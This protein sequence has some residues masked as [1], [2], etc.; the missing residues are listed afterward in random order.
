MSCF[1]ACAVLPQS[2]DEQL[3]TFEQEQAKVKNELYE[4]IETLK[5]ELQTQE[6]L[7]QENLTSMDGQCAELAAKVEGLMK[8]LASREEQWETFEKEAKAKETD[9]VAQIEAIKKEFEAKEK[10]QKECIEAK[11][12]EC[13]E[14]SSKMELLSSEMKK[15][16]QQ[17]TSFRKQREK[18]SEA[19]AEMKRALKEKRDEIVGLST[20]MELFVGELKSREERVVSIEQ[21]IE[22]K[23]EITAE[24]MVLWKRDLEEQRA[25]QEEW[26]TK[27]TKLERLMEEREAECK[28]LTT[29]LEKLTEELKTAVE[30]VSALESAIADKE[31]GASSKAESLRK[32]LEEEQTQRSNWNDKLIEINR[33]LSEGEEACASLTARLE[34]FNLELQARETIVTNLEE[35]VKDREEVAAFQLESLEKQLQEKIDNRNSWG[36]S[37]SEI[38]RLLE[39]KKER[40]I[41]LQTRVNLFN[42]ELQKREERVASLESV[43]KER[44]ECTAAKLE[45]YRNQLRMRQDDL[46][47][48]NGNTKEISRLLHDRQDQCVGLNTRLSLFKQQLQQYEDQVETLTEKVEDKMDSHNE[49]LTPLKER[50][51]NQQTER[52]SWKEKTSAIAKQL[53]DRQEQCVGLSTRLGLFQQQTKYHKEQVAIL[54]SKVADL[55]EKYTHQLDPL[56]K[57]LQAQREGLDA[58]RVSTLNVERLLRETESECEELTSKLKHLV[59]ELQSC[60]QDVA[61]LEKKVADK[62]DLNLA[63][64][65]AYLADLKSQQEERQKWTN[66]TQQLEQLLKDKE[67]QIV[68]LTTRLSLFHAELSKKQDAVSGLEAKIKECGDMFDSEIKSLTNEIAFEKEQRD[69]C[70]ES[71]L[72]MN[73]SM[74]EIKEPCIGLTTRISLF[75]KE[76]EAREERVKVLTAQVQEKEDLS[77]SE[78]EPLREKYDKAVEDRDKWNDS[79]LEIFWM[80]KDRQDQTVGLSTRL[81]KTQMSLT[82]FPAQTRT[83]LT[84]SITPTELFMNELHKKEEAVENAEIRLKEA[85]QGMKQVQ[86]MKKELSEQVEQRRKWNKSADEISR[87]LQEK[88][89]EHAGAKEKNNLDQECSRLSAKLELFKEEIQRRNEKIKSLSVSAEQKE[90]LMIA[91][92]EAAWKVIPGLKDDRDSWMEKTLEINRKLK[93]VQVE[94]TGLTTRWELFKIEQK[95]KKDTFAALE[96]KLNEKEVHFASMIDPYKKELQ[97]Q[98]DLRNKWQE[99]TQKMDRL[100]KRKESE[101]ITFS[102][103][104][105]SSID[106]LSSRKEKVANLE[107]RLRDK[108]ELSVMEMEYLRNEHVAQKEDLA[109]WEKSTQKIEKLLNDTKQECANL[110]VR[111]QV[112]QRQVE[113]QD[114]RIA[115]MESAYT[116]KEDSAAAEMDVLR[117][118]LQKQEEARDQS[119]NSTLEINRQI[120]NK[121]SQRT[122]ISVRLHLFQ[123]ELENREECVA[124]LEDRLKETEGQSAMELGPIRTQLSNQRSEFQKWSKSTIDIEEQLKVR[125]EERIGLST[126]LKLF[127]LQ[128]KAVEDT[129]AGL[130]KKIEEREEEA[131]T[132]MAPIQNALQAQKAECDRWTNATKEIQELLEDRKAQI[133]GLA[134]RLSLFRGEV[135]HREEVVASIQKK[136]EEKEAE[137]QEEQIDPIKEQLAAHQEQRD[138]WAETTAGLVKMLK[139][140]QE[141]VAGLQ[142]R[143]SCFQAE[144]QQREEACNAAKKRFDDE[145]ELSGAQVQVLKRELAM[146]VEQ[147][148]KWRVA[149]SEMNQE[150]DTKKKECVALSTR[151][152]VFKQ[153][154]QKH[155]QHIEELKSKVIGNEATLA[156][157]EELKKEL[158]VQ[159]EHRD[160]LN[161]STMETDT[162]LKEK[163]DQCAGLATRLLVFRQELQKR[164]E[165]LASTETKIKEKEELSDAQI[166][167]LQKDLEAEREQREKWTETTAELKQLLKE[168]E[169]QCSTLSAELELLTS[170]QG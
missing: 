11:S 166:E 92:Q 139:E 3:A 67:G 155:D 13:S 51:Q 14:L 115:I 147:R 124:K 69:H 35:K 50:L 59:V 87:L 111:I 96:A 32:A 55:E 73:K 157:V 89:R 63:R 7:Q 136:L 102:T 161:K 145:R 26:S 30:K 28:D 170:F 34:M 123:S 43:L 53:K 151:V 95:N 162:L 132:D 131:A 141:H 106:E 75:R 146:Q 117:A 6:K 5:N 19:A 128:L 163:K 109:N 137:L 142:T 107:A 165:R 129:V 159:Q 47:K 149:T 25:E 24:Q 138:E 82:C 16:E 114:E 60:Q 81:G 126:R 78:L 2:R 79:T 31:S 160:S 169:A 158:R 156:E 18:W 44:E 80:L 153:E 83:L 77:R 57:E 27:T 10:S 22:A 86:N 23:K 148:D 93:A 64:R 17:L 135:K 48:W 104:L 37:S 122:N 164:I 70:L 118:Q 41:G 154:I 46:D 62:G 72:H 121:E 120:Q 8:E 39:E 29:K 15:G 1:C 125:D 97:I 9:S 71:T 110:K 76:L 12:K 58:W 54:E 4:Q 61:D 66:S 127:Q 94:C 49:G 74:K 21:K 20:R 116:T 42:V 52:D 144:L 65:E 90:D 152:E 100:L 98:T 68:G 91:E 140:N 101:C 113:N 88:Q 134:T 143:L 56:K 38:H 167:S 133:T 108:K 112:F 150:L 105:E 36:K 119:V 130:E 99:T 45:P 85:E 84:I 103:Q 33:G 40:C 168:K